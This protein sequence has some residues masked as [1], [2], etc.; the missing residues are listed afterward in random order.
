MKTKYKYGKRIKIVNVAQM[1]KCF[2]IK[3]LKE[4]CIN[5]YLTNNST[6]KR[7]KKN[8]KYKGKEKSR[9]KSIKSGWVHC[10]QTF[11]NSRI[12]NGWDH[13]SIKTIRG[14]LGN[15]HTVG[16]LHLLLNRVNRVNGLITDNVI[17][18]RRWRDCVVYCD[19][20][21]VKVGISGFHLLQAILE[22]ITIVDATRIK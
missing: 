9:R 13:N 2:Y 5:Y 20:G 6:K 17:S 15:D 10:G 3:T 14:K 8:L 18:S 21:K 1:G 4:R 12:L 22:P 11:S 19:L 16:V 7:K